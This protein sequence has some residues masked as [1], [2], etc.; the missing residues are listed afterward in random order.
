M[1]NVQWNKYVYPDFNIICLHVLGQCILIINIYN[2]CFMYQLK[3]W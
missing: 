1:I 2:F 3:K